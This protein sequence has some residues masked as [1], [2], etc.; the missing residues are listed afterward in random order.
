MI[1]FLKF[2][3]IFSLEVLIIM[4]FDLT[5]APLKKS[6][7]LDSRPIFNLFKL[8]HLFQSNTDTTYENRMLKN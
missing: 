2:S 7:S 3:L 4:P 1:Q 6:G 5:F 8:A